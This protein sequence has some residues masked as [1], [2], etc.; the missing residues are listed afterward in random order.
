MYLYL[1]RGLAIARANQ[2]W[3]ANVTYIPMRPG[4]AYLVVIMDWYSRKVHAW[5]LSN[6][7][8]TDFYVAEPDEALAKHG[9]P[10]I[11]N[12]DQAVSLRARYSPARSRRTALVGVQR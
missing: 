11:F 10:E 2:V 8:D 7:F 9:R 4:L 1:L 5:R 12:T 6:T 3:C